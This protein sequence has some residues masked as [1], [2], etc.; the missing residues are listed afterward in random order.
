MI[1]HAPAT[2]DADA[3]SWHPSACLK[4][5]KECCAQV[6]QASRQQVTPVFFEWIYFFQL[7]KK[8]SCLVLL[9]RFDLF[10]SAKRTR[11]KLTSQLVLA[12]LCP[13]FIFCRGTKEAGHARCSSAPFG[14]TG[15][16]GNPHTPVL[17]A[18]CTHSEI[19]CR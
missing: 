5:D 14:S 17:R 10:F 11:T 19:R 2:L 12:R 3:P 6:V 15:S 1:P 18:V 7:N 13:A 16:P 8:L 4:V 9:G